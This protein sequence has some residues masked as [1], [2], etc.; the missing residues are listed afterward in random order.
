MPAPAKFQHGDKFGRLMI[1]GEG[2]GGINPS[3]GTFRNW[4]CLCECGNKLLV[5]T[6][7]LIKGAT[8]SCGCLQRETISAARKKHGMSS[9]PIYNN[10]RTML[11][12]CSNPNDKSFADYGAKGITVWWK[13]F[14]NFLDD[15]GLPPKNHT[16][17]RID[18]SLG[19]SPGNCRW[20]TRHEQSRNRSDNVYVEYDGHK[21]ILADA[22]KFLTVTPGAL[23]MRMKR[24]S[25]T[26]QEAFDH[27]VGVTR[28]QANLLLH[29]EE[30]SRQGLRL[31]V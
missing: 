3:G 29:V 27:F 26:L 16:L 9:T 17:E 11:T 14:Q 20:A 5:R 31:K 13:T 25:E 10:W 15:M 2:P 18:N 4:E 7:S 28:S 23:Y 1:L 24:Q 6:Q 19:Y 21:W 8:K 12:R 22:M 30:N